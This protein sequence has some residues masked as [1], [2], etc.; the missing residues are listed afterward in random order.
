MHADFVRFGEYKSAPEQLTNEE[1]SAPAREQEASLVG[2]LHE[3][4]VFDLARWKPAFLE[5]VE[6]VV[7]EATVSR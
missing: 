6:A 4:L 5:L 7:Q 3:R 1:L 2:D